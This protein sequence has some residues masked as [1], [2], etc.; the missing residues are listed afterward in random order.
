MVEPGLLPSTTIENP[1][2]VTGRFMFVDY[3]MAEEPWHERFIFEVLEN[4]YCVVI[5]PDY[6][7]YVEVMQVGPSLIRNMRLCA[8][9]ARA[10][11]LGLGSAYRQPCYRFDSHIIPHSVMLEAKKLFDVEKKRAHLPIKDKERGGPVDSG[12]DGG[13]GDDDGEPSGVDYSQMATRLEYALGVAGR[14]LEGV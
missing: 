3:G 2:P 8:A 5:T 13:D 1:R 14:T 12:A 10:V 11:P 4:R 9:G 7:A 6:D